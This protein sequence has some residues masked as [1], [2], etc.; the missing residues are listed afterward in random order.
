MSQLMDAIKRFFREDNWSF[1]ESQMDTGLSLKFGG[2]YGQWNCYARVREEGQFV[3]FSYAPLD[4]P[5]GK[6]P[7]ITEYITRANFG[8]YIGD[9]EFNYMTGTVQF[10][11]SIDVRGQET[12]LSSTLIK[13]LVYTNVVTMDKYLPGL[14]MVVTGKA[15]PEQAIEQAEADE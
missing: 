2:N 1:T 14:E 8:L 13:H 11:T 10:K 7:L 9:F 5:E 6:Y 4:I 3:F 15:T 12:D